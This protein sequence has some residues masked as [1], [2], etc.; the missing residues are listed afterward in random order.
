MSPIPCE[1]CYFLGGGPLPRPFGPFA[2]FGPLPLS[3]GGGGGGGGGGGFGAARS[4]M[5]N[6]SD[7]NG[8]ERNGATMFGGS[9]LDR[10]SPRSI[11]AGCSHPQSEVVGSMQSPPAKVCSLVNDV[12]YENLA[13]MIHIL[14]LK[15]VSYESNSS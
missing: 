3:A 15:D 12:M 11:Q 7:D 10:L 13:E 9:Q 5:S 1:A 2:A 4:K 8:F 14:M 6:S